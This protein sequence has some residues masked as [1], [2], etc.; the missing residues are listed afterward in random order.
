MNLNV[1]ADRRARLLLFAAAVSAL[2]LVGAAGCASGPEDEQARTTLKQA[3]REDYEAGRFAE[4]EE[5]LQEVLA[6]APDDVEA[7]Q[8]LALAQAAQG[9]NEEAL[10]TYAE[11]VEETPE[12]H[13]SWYRMALLERVVGSAKESADHLKTALELNPGDPSYT[14]ELARTQMSLGRYEEAAALWGDLLEDADP[15]DESRKELFLLQGQAYQAAKDYG[16][17]KQAFEAA[18]EL[19]PDDEALRARVDSFE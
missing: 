6:S 17:A 2:I 16:S 7:M 5:A 10:E 9:K 15:S 3:A 12:D 18:L 11:I 1:R 19:D 8:T 4:S 14:D 13:A